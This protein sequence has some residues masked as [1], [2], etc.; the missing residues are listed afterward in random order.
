MKSYIQAKKQK[1]TPQTKKQNKTQTNQPNKKDQ[2]KKQNGLILPG[3]GTGQYKSYKFQKESRMP[4]PEVCIL[5]HTCIAQRLIQA[6]SSPA[7]P[8]VSSIS[9]VPTE[10]Q[11]LACGHWLCSCWPYLANQCSH[12]H[13][14]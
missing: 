13:I 1:K 2:A 8:F 6:L 4:F 9:L 14:S 10:R 12:H 5:T 7:W 3:P 11:N